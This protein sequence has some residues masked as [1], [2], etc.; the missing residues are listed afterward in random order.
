MSVTRSTPDLVIDLTH[1]VPEQ[2][3]MQT[4]GKKRINEAIADLNTTDISLQS[5]I[6]EM[7]TD[8]SGFGSGTVNT[9]GAPVVSGHLAVFHDTTGLLIADGGAIPAGST[10]GPYLVRSDA[11]ALTASTIATNTAAGNNRYVLQSATGV[12]ITLPLP[13]GSGTVLEF[14]INLKA[15]T[16]GYVFDF[17]VSP[18]GSTFKST[19]L[20]RAALEAGAVTSVN[21]TTAGNHNR[22]TL[23]NGVAGT[24]GDVNDVITFTDAISGQYQVGGLITVDTSTA[25]FSAY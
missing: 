15:T 16:N 23:L 18:G 4:N 13:T 12:P 17:G 6:D 22:I 3:D 2:D 11:T 20:G 9:F 21:V 10:P 1:L 8:L 5:Q 14:V 25:T 7:E 19:L 24:G